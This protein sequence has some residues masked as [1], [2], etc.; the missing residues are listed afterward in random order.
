LRLLPPGTLL[1]VGRE[2]HFY[3]SGSKALK[4]EKDTAY[5]LASVSF[6][7]KTVFYVVDPREG[8]AVVS[9]RDLGLVPTEVFNALVRL[10][11][12]LTRG[13]KTL[14]YRIGDLGL[15]SRVMKLVKAR[16][17]RIDRVE[18]ISMPNRK[19][20]LH[21]VAPRNVLSE[22]EFNLILRCLKKLG[23]EPLTEGGDLVLLTKEGTRIRCLLYADA[24][25]RPL[26]LRRKM[27]ALLPAYYFGSF[28]GMYEALKVCR[29]MLKGFVDGSKWKEVLKLLLE[30][31]NRFDQ[32]DSGAL[33][34]IAVAALIHSEVMDALRKNKAASQI[35]KRLASSCFFGKTGTVLDS[36]DSQ[37][38]RELLRI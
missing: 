21:V 36:I 10:Q 9:Q 28:R 17:V 18:R 19:F 24:D 25:Q 2:N 32:E 27:I 15:V 38:L 11:P 35:V 8:V 13:A 6:S 29:S 34:E 20:T 30:N 22:D 14:V 33:A 31:Y 5:L 12:Y 3:V 7:P 37:K 16:L 23:L 1:R 4:I 26:L